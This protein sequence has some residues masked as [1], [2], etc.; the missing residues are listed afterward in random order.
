[1]KRVDHWVFGPEATLP[2]TQATRAQPKARAAVRVQGAVMSRGLCGGQMRPA[3]GRS[4]F[5]LAHSSGA[6]T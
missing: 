4:W 2:S 5:A 3:Y 6:R 1:M